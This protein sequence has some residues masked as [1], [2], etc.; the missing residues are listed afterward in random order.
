M[1]DS[2]FALSVPW[3]AFAKMREERDQLA[4]RFDALQT[5]LPEALTTK[6]NRLLQLE[7]RAAQLQREN[8]RLVREQKETHERNMR[9]RVT[10][11]MQPADGEPAQHSQ[12]GTPTLAGQAPGV[13][14]PVPGQQRSGQDWNEQSE[15]IERLRAERDQLGR[16]LADLLAVLPA[17]G[18][19]RCPAP[20]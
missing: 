6:V 4:C 2:G 18:G 9:M 12:E 16:R 13:D 17:T 20:T 8:A 3:A 7:M 14:R 11:A 15:M 10:P 19:A 1:P 5:I